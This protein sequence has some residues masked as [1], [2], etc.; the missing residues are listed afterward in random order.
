MVI[1]IFVI[2]VVTCI[3]ALQ[4]THVRLSG[5]KQ[6]VCVGNFDMCIWIL[7]HT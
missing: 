3:A 4:P 5:L 7:K 2:F 6:L 1:M